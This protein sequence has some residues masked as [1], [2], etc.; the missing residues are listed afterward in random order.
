MEEYDEDEKY[1]GVFHPLSHPQSSLSSPFMRS[2][3]SPSPP[4]REVYVRVSPSHSP[5][6]TLYRETSERS[7]RI[8]MSTNEEHTTTTT[9]QSEQEKLIQDFDQGRDPY[10]YYKRN[11]IEKSIDSPT[12]YLDDLHLV[13][14]M[15]LPVLHL[16][17]RIRILQKYGPLI[18]QLK[19]GYPITFHHSMNSRL[20]MAFA[21]YFGISVLYVQNRKIILAYA[22]PLY[23]FKEGNIISLHPL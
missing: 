7:Q 4:F 10:E 19:S 22:Y 17:F 20:F 9:T 1:R 11:P 13:K 5:P 14:E 6:R 16:P 23:E 8:R 15:G 3:L 18:T 21:R 2:T 12:R